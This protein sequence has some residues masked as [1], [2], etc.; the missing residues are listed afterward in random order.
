MTVSSSQA[1]L[2]PIAKLCNATLDLFDTSFFHMLDVIINQIVAL[3]CPLAERPLAL[4]PITVKA[5]IFRLISAFIN[6]H[7]K[8]PK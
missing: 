6:I 8:P 1:S 7:R 2:N 5:Q 4:L 3:S